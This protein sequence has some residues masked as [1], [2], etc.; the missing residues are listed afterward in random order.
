LEENRTAQLRERVAREAA[1][2]LY[3]SQEKEYKQAKRRAAETLGVRV[4]PSNLEVARELDKI[5]DETEESSRWERLL[6]MRREAL[7]IMEA[8]KDFSPRLVGSVWRG[9]AHRNSDIDIAAFS[10]RPE[11]VLARLKEK[12]FK[13]ERT[14]RQSV[15]KAGKAESSFH[16]Y[17]TLSSGNRAEVVVRDPEKMDDLRRCEIYGDHITGLSYPQLR[18]VLEESPLTRFV[19]KG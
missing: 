12:N 1:I 18:K 17:L 3:I 8:L 5:A 7:K 6:Q 13:V 4:L 14:E 11:T 2:L 16:I 15:T 10:S 9:T 19:P